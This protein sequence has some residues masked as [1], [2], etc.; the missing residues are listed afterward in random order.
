MEYGPDLTDADWRKSSYSG[1]TGGECVECTVTGGAAWRKSSYSGS[2]GGDCVEVAGDS[3]C[4]S[5]P[6]RD[7]KN[8]TGP[9]IVLGAHAWQTFVNDLR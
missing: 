9:T 3:S 8:P 2:T 5:V 4:G 6:V 1:N 7:S